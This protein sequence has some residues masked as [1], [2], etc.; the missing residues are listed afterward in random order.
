MS[1]TRVGGSSLRVSHDRRGA[2]HKP[3]VCRR[4][5][6]GSRRPLH[7]HQGPLLSFFGVRTPGVQHA[8]QL[9]E[10]V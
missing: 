2:P 3:P 5:E 8:S 7:D 10:I 9:F 1:A 6:A 4:Y